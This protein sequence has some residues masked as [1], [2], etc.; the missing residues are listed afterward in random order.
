VVII[1]EKIFGIFTLDST[2]FH[3]VGGFTPFKDDLKNEKCL[4][5][6]DEKLFGGGKFFHP[7]FFDDFSFLINFFQEFNPPL[8]DYLV[9]YD[10]VQGK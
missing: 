9:A 3:H 5:K 7:S 4:K 10:P 2:Q 6:V 1:R 8:D